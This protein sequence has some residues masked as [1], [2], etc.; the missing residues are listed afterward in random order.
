MRAPD[1]ASISA[2]VKAAASTIRPCAALPL[3]SAFAPAN[4]TAIS[5]L[6]N[7]YCGQL[8]ATPSY[9]DAFFGAGLDA[10]LASPAASFFNSAG[11]RQ[12]VENA[13]VSNAIGSNVSP[14]MATAVTGEV[15]NLLQLFAG[16]SSNGQTPLSGYTVSAAAQAACAA[17][18]GSAA[19]MLQ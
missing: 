11:N 1:C 2:S 6:A 15:D 10:S 13:L 17:T 16:V 8:L 18:L 9:R 3:I 14:Q 7:A 12:I 19:V 5:Q 4:Q